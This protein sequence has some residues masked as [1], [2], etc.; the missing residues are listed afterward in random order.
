MQVLTVYC[1]YREVGY[2]LIELCMEKIVAFWIQLN[3]INLNQIIIP[4][5]NWENL[6]VR[7]NIVEYLAI[8]WYGHFMFTD[9]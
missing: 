4:N 7:I 6:L 5:K 1:T 2:C 3:G 9:V 8:S